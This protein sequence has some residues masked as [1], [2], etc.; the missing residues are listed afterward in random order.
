MRNVADKSC[1][2][3]ENSHF[4]SINVFLIGTFEIM[5]KFIV[6]RGR[7]HDSISHAHCM[8]CNWRYRRKYTL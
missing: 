4:W 2:E 3:N 1:G 8:P 5:R 7:P 6:Q